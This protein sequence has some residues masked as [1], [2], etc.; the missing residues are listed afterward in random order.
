MDPAMR[1]GVSCNESRVFPVGI[2]LQ[3]N[4]VSYTGFGFTVYYK[5]DVAIK[6]Y[7]ISF[8]TGSTFDGFIDCTNEYQTKRVELCS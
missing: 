4:P 7:V 1:T 8:L 6:S 2:D 3:G 5:V